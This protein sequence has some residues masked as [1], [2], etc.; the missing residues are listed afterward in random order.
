MFDIGFWELIII[1]VVALLVVGPDKLP[2]LI[3]ETARWFARIRKFVVE[4]KRDIER[5]IDFDEI[6]KDM[7]YDAAKMEDVLENELAAGEKSVTTPEDDQQSDKQA[8]A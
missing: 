6:E 4:T 3:R 2:G 1:G 8:T 5:Q 7:K